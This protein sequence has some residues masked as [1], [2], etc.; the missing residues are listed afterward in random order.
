MKNLFQRTVTGGLFGIMVYGS[1]FA[2]RVTFLIF[3]LALMIFTLLEFYTHKGNTG[4]KVQKYSALAISVMLFLFTYGYVTGNLSPKWFSLFLLCPPLMM[5]RQ[6]YRRDGNSFGGLAAAFYGFIYIAVPF[7]LLNFLVFP[8]HMQEGY[9]PGLLAGILILIMLND[10]AGFLVGVPLGRNRLFE[11]ISPKKSWEGTLG[12]VVCVI[13][14]GLFMNYLF[15]VL[16]RADWLVVSAITVTFGI[17]GD[18]VESQLKRNLG[19]KDS[20]KLLPGHGGILDR[21]DAWLFVI[22]AVW[23]YINFIF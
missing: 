8:G 23:V 5:I 3:Y 11:S 15:P 22:P 12:G 16:S 6:L 4:L 17:Y 7:S 18:L 9:Y 10:T 1:L 21:V 20:G 19:I 14:A 2:G 13:I